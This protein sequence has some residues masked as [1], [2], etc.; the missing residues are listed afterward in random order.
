MGHRPQVE[1]VFLLAGARVEHGDGYPG[2]QPNL[3]SPIMK[4]SRDA[5]KELYGVEPAIKAIH[6]GLECGILAG[7]IKDL[8]RNLAHLKAVRKT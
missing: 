6:A 2:W 8:D 7:K 4:I 1:A 3:E 5:Y